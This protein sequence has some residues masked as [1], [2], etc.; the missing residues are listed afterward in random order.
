LGG[1]G[2]VSLFKSKSVYVPVVTN[3]HCAISDVCCS[4]VFLNRWAAARY[5]ALVSIIPGRERREETTICCEI[6]LVRLITNL[7]VELLKLFH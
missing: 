2:G 7:N 4:A 5:R 6:S 3:A 1:G